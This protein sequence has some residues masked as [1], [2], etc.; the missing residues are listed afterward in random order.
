MLVH[1]WALDTSECFGTQPV[2]VVDLW[3]DL[4]FVLSEKRI[5]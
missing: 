2:A 1:P 3:T 5:K 4:L